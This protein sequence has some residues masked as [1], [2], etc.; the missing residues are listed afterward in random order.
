MGEKHLIVAFEVIQA[1]PRRLVSM[2]EQATIDCERNCGERPNF[3][4]VQRNSLDFG[5][6]IGERENEV[7]TMILLVYEVEPWQNAE[8]SVIL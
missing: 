8:R 4:N 6:Y 3:K 1:K 2:E 5:E 7:E